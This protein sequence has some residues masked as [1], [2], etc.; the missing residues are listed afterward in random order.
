MYPEIQLSKNALDYLNETRKW[1]YFLSIAGFIFCGLM[2]IFAISFGTIISTIENFS[3]DFNSNPISSFGIGIITATYL[4]IAAIC[5]ILHLYL[6]SFSL[7]LKLAIQTKDNTLLEQGFKNLKSYWKI[8]GILTA[9]ALGSYVLI[10]L[11]SV[12]GIFAMGSMS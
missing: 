11:L 5:L 4:L 1:T 6:Y 8:T 3:V 12:V 10:F 9:I 2:V 7:N